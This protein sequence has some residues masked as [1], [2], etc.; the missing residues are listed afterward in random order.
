MRSEGMATLKEHEQELIKNLTTDG[1]R[2]RP[3]EIEWPQELYCV[4]AK[5][6]V[7]ILLKRIH[8]YILIKNCNYEDLEKIV[9]L[10]KS[11]FRTYHSIWIVADSF[12]EKVHEFAHNTQLFGLIKINVD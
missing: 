4:K 6:R 5:R 2:A 1:W 11:K 10:I 12:T 8:I 9:E 3:H 7:Y